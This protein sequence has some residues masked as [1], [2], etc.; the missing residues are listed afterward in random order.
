M[1]LSNLAQFCS[2]PHLRLRPPRTI[3]GC[4]LVW[5]RTFVCTVR[6][7]AVLLHAHTDTARAAPPSYEEPLFGGTPFRDA[8]TVEPEDT[9]AETRSYYSLLNVDKDATEEQIRDAYKTLAGAYR[10]C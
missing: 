6:P 7:R 2:P 3:R 8:H 1:S 10:V 4:Q 9:H 5:T